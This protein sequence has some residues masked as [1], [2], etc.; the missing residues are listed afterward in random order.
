[1]EDGPPSALTPSDGLA[2]LRERQDAR[3]TLTWKGRT[4]YDMRRGGVRELYGG[5]LAQA[6]GDSTVV[7]AQLPS[8]IR[9]IEQKVWTIEDVGMEMRDFGMDPAED[10][11]PLLTLG[12]RELRVCQ[13]G[14]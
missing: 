5:I 7:C 14:T 11:R 1:M 12:R 8:A 13:T 2:I 9:G 4:E 10:L 3:R 6:D